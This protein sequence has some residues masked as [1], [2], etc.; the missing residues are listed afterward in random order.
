MRS[1]FCILAAMFG[2]ALPNVRADLY[3]YPTGW[4][5]TV[6]ER[7]TTFLAKVIASPPVAQRQSI[8]YELRGGS[9]QPGRDFIAASGTLTF[10]PGETEKVIPVKL[11]DDAEIEGLEVFHLVIS[12]PQ[13]PIYIYEP[14]MEFRVEDDEKGYGVFPPRVSEDAPFAPVKVR[15]LGDFAFESSI[16]LYTGASTARPGVDYHD[17]TFHIVFPPGVSERTVHVRLLN[18]SDEDGD[19]TIS[20]H[21]RNPTG[22]I[23]IM[24]QGSIGIAIQDNETGY[25]LQTQ[26]TE[27]VLYEGGADRLFLRRD[28]DYNIQSVATVAIRAGD[29]P[30]SP[31]QPGSDFI[32]ESFELTFAPGQNVVEIPIQIINDHEFEPREYLSID[33]RKSLT[34]PTLIS[35]PV[36]IVDNEFNPLPVAKLCLDVHVRTGVRYF[37]HW[38]TKPVAVRNGFLTRAMVGEYSPFYAVIRLAN[39]GA[40][41]QEFSPIPL[42]QMWDSRLE[43]METPMG[44]YILFYNNTARRYLNSGDLDPTFAEVVFESWNSA[45]Q[46]GENIYVSTGRTLLRLGKNG[47]I[48]QSFS[49]PPLENGGI[50]TVVAAPSG[51]VYVQGDFTLSETP[52]ITNYARLKLDGAVDTSFVPNGLRGQIF[53]HQGRLFIEPWNEPYFIQCVAP[54][55][56]VDAT[57]NN[58]RGRDQIAFD[59]IGNLYVPQYEGGGI[60]IYKYQPN[61][62]VDSTFMRGETDATFLGVRAVSLDGK[63]MLVAGSQHWW[64]LNG[65]DLS[66]RGQY[67]AVLH[68][69][70]ILDLTSPAR[71][72][73]PPNIE[74]LEEPSGRHDAIPFTRTGVNESS[75]VT[76]RYRTRNG[77]A[78][79]GSDFELS[80]EGEVRFEPGISRINLPVT[81]FD[82]AT[83]ELA[84]WFFVDLLGESGAVISTCQVWI[85]N[86]DHG[87][88]I[89][90]IENNR[91][92]MRHIRGRAGSFEWMVSSTLNDWE[93]GFFSYDGATVEIDITGPHRFIHGA[94][95]TSSETIPWDTRVFIR[96]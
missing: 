3:L 54:D 57:F 47:G 19:R 69:L 86:D 83:P 81:I 21:L 94:P 37:P 75:S 14:S 49:F 7:E 67:G 18:D 31:A 76:A 40:V 34:D 65:V 29:I 12:N 56:R 9:A 51:T 64:M 96:R 59:A 48:D 88:E 92:Q 15:R 39:D 10:E 55:G 58:V 17:E 95:A 13:P 22:G 45:V 41:D 60:S 78:I 90:G 62:T 2:L 87:I 50:G 77:P 72:T 71:V 42:T 26:P 11:L 5:Q 30:Y 53:G 16:D 20:L 68:S 52:A 32:G 6:A 46:S 61:A 79:N 44:D 24:D 93:S 43:M 74:L 91:M 82:N 27:N 33:H 1:L 23:P 38:Q 80:P 70:G 25:R 63:T 35:V 66:C 73:L 89:L 36:A 85:L 8:D 4:W 28:G 84:K